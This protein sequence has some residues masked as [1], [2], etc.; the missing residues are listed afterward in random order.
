ME[1]RKKTL[2]STT[3]LSVL[4]YFTNAYSVYISARILILN[5]RLRD[6]CFLA[7]TSIE[8]YIKGLITIHGDTV[9]RHHDLTSSKLLNPLKNKHKAF[10]NQL[11]QDFL[12][13]LS[14]AYQ[15][16]YLD[17]LALDFNIVILKRKT[18]AELDKVVTFIEEN[19]SIVNSKR[20][21]GTKHYLLDKENKNPHLWTGN[22]FLN[23][24]DQREFVNKENL[25]YE[26]RKTQTSG[27]MEVIYTTLQ[28]AFDR[29]FILEG[30]VETEIGKIFHL[31]YKPLSPE[32]EGVVNTE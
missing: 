10:Y 16:R 9:P 12:T 26:A 15:M 29:P 17:S 21:D 22:Y 6:A 1:L 19:V 5:D 2:N 25:V 24:I 8:K 3:G 7:N 4:D 20:P 14:L 13:F 18:L 23:N 30:F 28:P 32:K 27:M 31:A 11:N